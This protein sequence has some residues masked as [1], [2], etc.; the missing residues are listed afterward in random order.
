M[1]ASRHLKAH[2][3]IT[4]WSLLTNF[5]ANSVVGL[6][7]KFLYYFVSLNQATV[8]SC[9]ANKYVQGFLWLDVKKGCFSDILT[10]PWFAICLFMSNGQRKG[11]HQTDAKVQ[12]LKVAGK[13]SGVVFFHGM[14]CP[15]NDELSLETSA[16]LFSVIMSQCQ[17]FTSGQETIFFSSS[18]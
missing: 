11:K 15:R 6:Y 9:I 18:F 17:I 4:K 10:N 8:V 7:R 5:L 16:I 1:L 12:Q 3:N 14:F 13:N 2:Y